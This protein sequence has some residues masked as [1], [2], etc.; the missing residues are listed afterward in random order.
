MTRNYIGLACTFHDPA[1]AI[2]NSR[3]E[4]VFA[5]ATERPYQTK[6]ALRCLPDNVS[7]LEQVLRK[8][9]EPE[10]ELTVAK[11]WSLRYPK[12]LRW[13]WRLS[14]LLGYVFRGF[15]PLRM[16]GCALHYLIEAQLNSMA[17]AS[18]DLVRHQV[19]AQ[20][21]RAS[22]DDKRSR[23]RPP[24]VTGFNHHLAHAA[25]GCFTSPF[26]EAVCA[27]VDGFGEMTTTALYYY[28]DGQL[29]K[30]PWS[31]RSSGSLGVYYSTLCAACGFDAV[32][33]E[34]WKVMGLAPYGHRH[35]E[36]YDRL[37]SLFHIDGL[38]V[39]ARL[40]PGGTDALWRSVTGVA[41]ADLACTGQMVF[42]EWMTELLGNLGALGLSDN[43]VLGGGCAL[44][45]SYNGLI[46]ERTPFKNLHVFAAPA[47]DGNAVGAALLAFQEDHPDW[48]PSATWQSPYLGSVLSRE[49]IKNLVGFSKP[50]R[51]SEHPGTIH[52]VAA[53]AL[54]EG[55]IIGWVQ[56]RAEFGPRALGNR[57]ILAD[58]RRG[59]IKDQ[60]NGRVKFREEFRPFAP[61][62]LHEK[63]ADYFVNYQPTPYME[64]TLRFRDEVLDRVPGVVHV[65]KTGRLQTVRREWNERFWGLVQEFYQLTGVP[66]VLNTSFN[67]MG[68]PIVHSVEDAMAVLHTTG[69]DAI[70][71]EDY[72]VEK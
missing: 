67:V 37:K 57:S 24:R 5:E 3:G 50:G 34:E 15:D 22:P 60:I 28:R 69:L 41:A 1:L 62:I 58:A 7:Y 48:V 8:H 44:N 14:K 26:R 30:L 31:R 46:L 56:G 17:G 21:D 6:R 39:I 71:L 59:D 43:L 72:W 32:K 35:A 2:V 18:V 13:F 33:G 53:R 4:I 11:S 55:K 54:A 23:A 45:S 38:R 10:A 64:R 61:A 16:P 47:D 27:V 29:R 51:I 19:Q 9:C 40:T 66:I 49:V 65:N 36:T 68:K 52:Q 20:L 70:A 42:E 12:Q 25:A 63:G